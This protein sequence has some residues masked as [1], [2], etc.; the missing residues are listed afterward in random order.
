MFLSWCAFF[1]FIAFFLFVIL[2]SYLLFWP[3]IFFLP[4]R[5]FLLFFCSLAFNLLFTVRIVSLKK[6]K[7]NSLRGVKGLCACVSA[8][9][10][11]FASLCICL[12]S[13]PLI[14]CTA[15]FSSNTRTNFVSNGH[16]AANK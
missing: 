13:C 1:R 2:F 14:I 4:F 5:F 12:L 7:K 6:K 11:T 8:F 3:L 9:C 16:R 10:V 15:I